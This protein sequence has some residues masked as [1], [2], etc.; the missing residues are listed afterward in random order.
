MN[1]KGPREEM[2][3]VLKFNRG[4]THPERWV[5]YG[6]AQ[7]FVKTRSERV[8]RCPDCEARSFGHIGQ[9]VYYSTLVRLLECRQCGLVFV[10]TRIDPEVI[11]GHFEQA[12]KDEEYFAH[13]RRRVFEQMCGLV[14][15][16]APR[17]GTVLD[18]GGAKG[19]LLAA[20][21]KRR[22]DLDVVLNDLSR[23]ACV[24]AE[25]T[26]GLRTI[27]GG[28][29]ELEMSARR[30]DVVIFSDVI[31]Y[32]PE[33]RRLWAVLPRLVAE[34]AAV[35]IRVPN[36]LAII[37]LWQ[38]F[39]RAC[40]RQGANEMRDTI[41][42]FNPEH[43]YAFSRRYLLQRL[44]SLGFGEVCASPSEL[45]ACGRSDF[46]YA[47]FHHLSRLTWLVSLRTVL[48]TPSMMVIAKRRRSSGS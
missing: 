4:F 36:K 13:Q 28:V 6:I 16:L 9:F 7:N 25:A 34:D 43:L 29:T 5:D 8:E 44:R 33:L 26:Y 39:I 41:T 38:Q 2:L 47:S 14:D 46:R 42:F 22:P 35:V 30:F 27:V 24:H 17:G 1:M 19:H 21:K 32:E 11:Q 12:Y 23:D 48:I 31:Y 37:R 15:G 20:L 3:G 45:L 10:D 40:S 18:V